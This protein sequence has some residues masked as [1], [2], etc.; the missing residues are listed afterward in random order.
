MCVLVIF[1]DLLESLA[2]PLG[3]RSWAP[4]QWKRISEKQP[5]N[6]NKTC[7]RGGEMITPLNTFVRHK[8][9][10]IYLRAVITQ[11][12]Q[13]VHTAHF[14]VPLQGWAEKMLHRRACPI[15]PAKH[16]HHREHVCVVLWG[17]TITD[18]SD[19]T[20]HIQYYNTSGLV[21]WL[22]GD[23]G[24]WSCLEIETTHPPYSWNGFS[25]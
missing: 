17:P 7:G 6:V 5:E 1:S 23:R 15:P 22:Y 9:A 2:V 18:C 3:A 13:H 10:K 4:W 21:R 11:H 14:A 19:V 8:L 25:I 16:F 12:V 20:P 24:I